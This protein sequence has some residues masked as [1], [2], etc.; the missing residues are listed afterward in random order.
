M[1]DATSGSV[2]I[3]A[4]GVSLPDGELSHGEVAALASATEQNLRRVIGSTRIYASSESA[5]SLAIRAAQ[6]CLANANVAADEIDA[7][8]YCSASKRRAL[9]ASALLVQDAIGA[10]NA[11]CMDLGHNCTEL[12]SGFRAA[13]A[14]IRDDASVRRVLV[15]AGEEWSEY[16]PKR[17][18]GD[19]TDKSY[20][21]VLSD[22]GCAVLVGYTESSV[23]TGFGFSSIGKYY[24]ILKLRYEV[25]GD[26]VAERVYFKPDFPDERQ[27]ALDLSRLFRGALERCVRAAGI[28]REDID[29]IVFPFSG[30]PMQIGFARALGLPPDRIV[31]SETSPTHIGSPDMIH[32]YKL[33]L[34]SGRGKPGQNVLF[35]ARSIGIMRCSMLRL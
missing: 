29:H 13:R 14:M 24:D 31:R 1:T 35:A 21:N 9:F 10:H 17:V 27:L 25:T 4:I 2:G 26:K 30:P 34:D 20:P 6:Q 18:A 15:I 7:V 11:F 12:L 8:L 5:E 19:L 28:R 33:L 22:G 32:G 16:A 3:C 23:L